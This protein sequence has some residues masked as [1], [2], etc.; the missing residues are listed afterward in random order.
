[1]RT[2]QSK[3]AFKNDTIN[4]YFL[5]A[6]LTI[7]ISSVNA[8]TTAPTSIT[9]INSIC[10]GSNTT[11]TLSGGNLSAE[12]VDVWYEGS[13]G[14]P[15]FHEGWDTQ[16]ASILQT[17]IN[18][19][20]NGIL[21][22]TS[23][24]ADPQINM[25]NLGSFDPTVYKYINFR[26]RV[27]SGTAG[28][29]QFFF[30][31]GSMTIADGSK[32]VNKSLIS[33]NQWH[34]VSV[35]MSIHALWA[36]GGSI[37]GIRYDYATGS[38]ATLDLDFI[39]LS[40]APLV[41]TGSSITVTPSA[42]TTYY[43]N[44]KAYNANTTCVSQTVS[45]NPLPAAP[46]ATA[47]QRFCPSDTVASL[48]ATVAAGETLEWFANATGG[49]ALSAATTLSAGNYYAQAS[50]ALGCS[51]TRTLVVVSFNNALHLDGANDYVSLTSNSIPDGATAFT[52]E[53]WI[54][55]DN[56]NFDG[57]W[58]AIFGR[59]LVSGQNNSRVP[60]I[61]IKSDSNMM[62]AK[63]HL[64]VFEDN[65]LTD[66]GFVTPN[67]HIIPNVWSHLAVVKEGLKFKVYVNGI[68][69]YEVVA[70]NAVNITGAYQ[71]G[72]VDNYYAGLIDDVR[73]WNTSRSAPEILSKMNETLS[74]T[75]TGLV[76][77]YTFDQGIQN[78]SNAGLTTLYDKTLS[79]N[80]G[81]LNNFALTGVTSNYVPGYFAQIIGTS[82]I[83]LG[84]SS[85]LSHVI[86]GGSWTSSNTNIVTVSNSGLVTSVAVGSATVSYTSCGQTTAVTITVTSTPPTI[87]SFAPIAA[88]T[89]DSV[90]IT[91]TNFNLVTQVQFGNVSAS[92]FTIDSPT[93]ITAIVGAG[94]SGNVTLTKG[95][96]NVALP[97][98]IYKVV[99]YNFNDNALDET[100]A[101]R[102]GSISGG[103]TF[104]TGVE[105]QSA[106]F[107]RTTSNYIALPNNLIR[108]LSD[109][110]ISLR[111]KTISKGVLLGYQNQLVDGSASNYIPIILVQ[112]DGKLRATLWTSAS[113]DMSVVSATLVNDGNWH[114]IDMSVTPTSIN[115]YLDGALVGSNSSGTV[116]H[117]D[118]QYNQIGRGLTSINRDSAG[119][120]LDGWQGF[121]G[122]I[123]NFLILDKGQS[124]A[125][126]SQ[127]TQLPVPTITSFTPAVCNI[128]DTVTITGT[129]FTGAT[130]V[131]IGTLPVTNFTLV[132][133]TQITAV[134]T[135]AQ[136]STI[137][138]I[139]AAG[140]AVSAT[141]LTVNKLNPTLS[142][143]NNTTKKYFDAGFTLSPPTSTIAEAFS[144]SSSDL[145]VA[146][147]S[148]S[149]VT[150]TG[151]GTAA[152][153]ATQAGNA[154]YNSASITATLTVSSVSVLTNTGA[155]S[156]TN[157]NYVNQYG[158][159]GTY[160][161]MNKNGKSIQTK[162]Y[163]LSA[164]L[165]MHL[166]AGN[167]ASYPGTGTIW[168]DLSGFGNN[169]TLVNSP[170]YNSSNSGNL[171]FN[172]TT[173][174]VDAPLTKT[175]SC[176]F[177]VWAKSTSAPSSMLFNAGNHGTGPDLFF[178]GGV[179]NWNTWDSSANPFGSIPATALNGNWH[180]YV[181]V[182]DAVSNI[183]K[184]YYDGVLYGTAA[185]VN[186]SATTALYIGGS[187]SGYQWNGAIGVFQVHNRVLTPLDVLEN[188]NN[189]KT[190]YGL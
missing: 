170:T 28:V 173:T 10:N 13:C 159:I 72:Y 138:V 89:G 129:N 50:S 101:N 134:T 117:L 162:T 112:S 190:R 67:A 73:F 95:G 160:F 121:T 83:Q 153:T 32:Y 31:N 49:S 111:F 5:C 97:G 48:Q 47:I 54:K 145:N 187:S 55:P 182:N 43:A 16:P 9:G 14:G 22:V 69:V 171:V 99:E 37:T 94:S 51:S 35:N 7:F 79:A 60:S 169:G 38:G 64:S 107:D 88:G 115:F 122:C 23:T 71:I 17:T 96:A 98:F 188:F 100:D 167:A 177:S 104:G 76:D 85:Q 109:F 92:S 78:A 26:Y 165:V 91:G 61:Y 114:K 70:P 39:E 66:Y 189:L 6:I 4:F 113:V 62:N 102:D 29:A 140:T 175:A 135:L 20:L 25:F 1:M 152:I 168:T 133:D 74:G 118:M 2:C 12:T 164:G 139:T 103:V 24:G 148:G 80:N 40:A 34:T 131:V 186:A 147:I 27:V 45:V 144:Y 120:D 163:D 82:T 166:D 56:L 87:S 108:S 57:S 157:L 93:Q 15:A 119:G 184:L 123:D 161:G 44:R 143:F 18:S 127:V 8:Q 126:I 90:V 156:G 130:S 33:D 106:C 75:E 110:T 11:L 180:N 155:I 142:N 59:Q 146:T 84:T 46:T 158:Q 185:Y 68:F 178:S 41:G 125:T 65:T 53:A 52:I 174:Y 181:V 36:S 77:Y 176:T 42:T 3:F 30:L 150:I 128:G 86:S 172:G 105:G 151:V 137:S 149:V 132:S 63:I 141:N 58:H 179:L 19:N 154:D 183:T 81:T 136:V 116:A 124:L 21:N